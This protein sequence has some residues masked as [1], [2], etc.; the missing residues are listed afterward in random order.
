MRQVGWNERG[1][2]EGRDGVVGRIMEASTAKRR[3]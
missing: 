2:N 3:G 1:E